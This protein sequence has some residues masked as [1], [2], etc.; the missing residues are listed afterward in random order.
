VACGLCFE[1]D[2]VILLIESGHFLGD[3]VSSLDDENRIVR[4]FACKTLSQLA[5]RNP[6]VIKELLREL[7]TEIPFSV[8]QVLSAANRNSKH[9]Y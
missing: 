4:V 3:L 9:L 8:A 1:P 6:V 5:A 2:N 7:K